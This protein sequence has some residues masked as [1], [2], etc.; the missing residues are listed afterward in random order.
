MT[1]GFIDPGFQG[2]VTL[3]IV[4][5]GPWSITLWPEMKI[6]QV[7]FSTMVAPSKIPYGSKD[8]GSHYQ[9]QKGPTP[10]SGNRDDEKPL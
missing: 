9:G 1:A 5:L 4:N 8:L 6:A 10:A 2:Q 3:E 7:S